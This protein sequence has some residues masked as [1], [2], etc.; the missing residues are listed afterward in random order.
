MR[1]L[2]LGFCCLLVSATG[3]MQPNGNWNEPGK[4][5][6]QNTAQIIV[7]SRLVTSRILKE[8]PPEVAEKVN[9]VSTALAS[10]LGADDLKLSIDPGEAVSQVNFLI[11]SAFPEIKDNMRV[12]QIIDTVVVLA[13]GRIENLSSKFGSNLDRESA[14][15]KFIRAAVT[16][17][18][19]GS[20]PVS[21]GDPNPA[22]DI[23]DRVGEN[24]SF[25]PS[26]IRGPGG[27]IAENLPG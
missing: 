18:R 21:G 13:V 17:I 16:G 5:I 23:Q 4:I 6:D 20:A 7:V 15:I 3:C 22:S 11:A 8:Q 1:T 2:A 12:L 9:Q 19:N 24:T 14:M 10:I 26:P 27:R 25:K